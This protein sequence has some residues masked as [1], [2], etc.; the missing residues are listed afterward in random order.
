MQDTNKCDHLSCRHIGLFRC[1]Q[2]GLL[3]LVI[4]GGVLQ[5]GHIELEV[6]ELEIELLELELEELELALDL[7]EDEEEDEKL[8][9]EE[10]LDSSHRHSSVVMTLT[11]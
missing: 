11:K 5:V 3:R 8:A 9:T 2:L 10:L 7:S 1:E 4:A 6:L